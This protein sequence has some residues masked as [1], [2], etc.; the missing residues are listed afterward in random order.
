MK[1]ERGEVIKQMLVSMAIEVPPRRAFDEAAFNALVA[2][3]QGDP[4]AVLFLVVRRC[5]L[6]TLTWLH[7]QGAVTAHDIRY[8]GAVAAAFRRGRLDF[9]GWMF[10]NLDLTSTNAW[11]GFNAAFVAS[12][13]EGNLQNIQWLHSTVKERAD[14]KA[15]FQRAARNGCFDVMIWMHQVFQLTKQ[16][17]ELGV[18]EIVA[19]KG[20]LDILQWLHT[21]FAWTIEDLRADENAAL[22]MA[23][24]NGYLHILKWMKD[25]FPLATEDVRANSNY[26]IECAVIN[27]HL[28]VVRWFQENYNLEARDF[29]GDDDWRRQMA[30][31]NDKHEVLAWL[32]VTFGS[33][34]GLSS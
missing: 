19:L 21:A 4:K 9:L 33:H 2:S 1:N 22:G 18:F 31:D 3:S 17:I 32:S 26:A 15:A 7:E 13:G 30:I 34:T 28:K 20:R 29:I 12:A 25:V 11:E 5:R 16:D 10:S 27:G 24:N 14:N 23:A 8:S 6:C